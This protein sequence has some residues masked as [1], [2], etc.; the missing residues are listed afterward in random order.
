MR[1]P[2]EAAAVSSTVCMPSVARMRPAGGARVQSSEA[3]HAQRHVVAQS[4]D[5]RGDGI[6]APFQPKGCL[7]GN[8]VL[9]SRRLPCPPTKEEE[10]GQLGQRI[11]L[12]ATGAAGGST[13]GA[14][15]CR[16]AWGKAGQRTA[17]QRGGTGKGPLKHGEQG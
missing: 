15:G 13:L 3:K 4:D 6:G 1:A 8:R 7:V 11:G 9:P 16:A 5:G 17:R 12:G 14:T 2:S 10:G